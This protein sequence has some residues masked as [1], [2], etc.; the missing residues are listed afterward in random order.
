MTP[1]KM[2][3]DQGQEATKNHLTETDLMGTSPIKIKN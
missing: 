1:N 3:F 2:E